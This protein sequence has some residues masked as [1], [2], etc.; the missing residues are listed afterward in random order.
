MFADYHGPG[1]NAR[2]QATDQAGFSGFY[3]AREEP[4]RIQPDEIVHCSRKVR[5]PTRGQGS[6][7]AQV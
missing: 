2:K 4:C 3:H 5:P 1:G 6:I 7:A